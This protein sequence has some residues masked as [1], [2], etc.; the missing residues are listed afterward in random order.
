VRLVDRPISVAA[1]GGRPA[2]FT[3]RGRTLT[4]GAV[5]EVWADTGEWWRGEPE[6][7]FYRLTAAGGLYELYFEPSSAGWHLYKVY[8]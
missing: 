2:A 4:V 7:I 6:K 8:D 3:W 5:L 1:P